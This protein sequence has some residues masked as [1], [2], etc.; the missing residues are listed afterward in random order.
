MQHHARA[1]EPLDN[2]EHLRGAPDGM[3]GYEQSLGFGNSEDR[4]KDAR[5][6]V[7]G[8]AGT[9]VEADLSDERGVSGGSRESALIEV[10][11]GFDVTWVAA[12]PRQFGRPSDERPRATLPG[13]PSWRG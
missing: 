4:G 5:L 2:L 13:I 10:A 11:Q 9:G 1:R 6:E 8:S 3:H 7:A 12:G